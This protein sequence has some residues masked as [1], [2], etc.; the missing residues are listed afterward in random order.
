[1]R[2]PAGA[3]VA[4]ILALVVV[5]L[6]GVGIT[7]YFNENDD[8]RYQMSR[9]PIPGEYHRA[10]LHD[11]HVDSRL[12]DRL[13][14]RGDSRRSRITAT[15][16]GEGAEI[17]VCDENGHNCNTIEVYPRNSTRYYESS[18]QS[19]QP[20]RYVSNHGGACS[21]GAARFHLLPLLPRLHGLSRW[22]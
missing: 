19:Y 12:N 13:D 16:K 1:M 21:G 18:Y 6:A 9:M 5:V 14:Y 2:N 15:R 11:R 7:Q 8:D 3:A 10:G 4:V 22:R 17:T 20:V